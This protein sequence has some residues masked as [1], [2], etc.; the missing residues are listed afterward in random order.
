M[1]D[2]FVTCCSLIQVA[3]FRASAT[4]VYVISK[5]GIP[6]PFEPEALRNDIRLLGNSFNFNFNLNL[7]N[8]SLFVAALVCAGTLT[9]CERSVTVTP[10]VAAPVVVQVPVAV[11]GPPGAT[12]ATG[13]TGSDGA[14][15]ATGMGATGATGATGDTG[16]TGYTGA[17]GARGRTGAGETGA[18]GATG[19]TGY[20]GATGAT[21]DTGGTG[22]TGATGASGATGRTGDLIVVVPK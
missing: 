9:A 19:A 2:D 3:V 7:M 16:A 5:T 18:T 13:S 14:R 12:G 1:S 8:H 11:P 15:G 20:T 21:G 4:L 17:T 10:P 6:K 22:A